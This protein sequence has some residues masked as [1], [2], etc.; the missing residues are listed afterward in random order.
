MAMVVTFLLSPALGVLGNWDFSDFPS[1]VWAQIIAI[2][3]ILISLVWY[4]IT[5]NAQKAKG[6]NVDFAFKEIPP[7]SS[8]T[9]KDH[10]VVSEEY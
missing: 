1:H 7:S 3:L 10:E 6:I 8:V 9:P 4:L 2:G 5:K